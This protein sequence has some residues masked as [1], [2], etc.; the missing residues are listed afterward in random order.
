MVG[1]MEDICREL[2]LPEDRINT[3]KW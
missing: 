2:G 3:E 1:A